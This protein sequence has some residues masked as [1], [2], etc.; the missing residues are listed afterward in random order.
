MITLLLISKLSLWLCVIGG[1]IILLL[2]FYIILVKTGL[3]GGRG[4]IEPDET[5]ISEEHKYFWRK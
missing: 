4:N 3:R 2:I 5:F 1:M